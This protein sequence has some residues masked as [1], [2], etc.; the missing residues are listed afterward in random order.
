MFEQCLVDPRLVVPTP[1]LVHLISEI[2][3]D[4][5][6]QPNGNLRLSGFGLDDRASLSPREANVPIPFSCALFHGGYSGGSSERL[7]VL[8]QPVH[9][10]VSFDTARSKTQDQTFLF[11]DRCLNF[12]AIQDEERLQAQ[13]PYQARRR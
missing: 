3:Q 2:F 12:G 13:I 1:G 10:L 8:T 6:A 5:V 4:R 11:L 9:R 7:E